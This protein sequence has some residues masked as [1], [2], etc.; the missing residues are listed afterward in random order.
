MLKDGNE[1]SRLYLEIIIR[2]EI[3]DLQMVCGKI[4]NKLINFFRLRFNSSIIG[5]KT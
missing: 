5:K 3:Y 2:M 1:R 4:S